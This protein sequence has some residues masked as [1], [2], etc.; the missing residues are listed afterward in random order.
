MVYTAELA[1]EKHML[2]FLPCFQPDKVRH[3]VRSVTSNL[4]PSSKYGGFRAF[5]NLC[6]VLL[7]RMDILRH[8]F[9]H[10]KIASNRVIWGDINDKSFKLGITSL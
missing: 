5:M 2:V 10:S 9:M 3:S 1:S 7:Y 8:Q 6:S 4:F